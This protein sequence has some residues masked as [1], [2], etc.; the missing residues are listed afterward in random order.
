MSDLQNQLR[1][2]GLS[3]T[4]ASIYICGVSHGELGV[5]E[6]QKL[7]SIKRPTIYHALYGLLEKGL[8]AKSGSEARM[9][10]TFT[11]PEHLAHLAET[12]ILDIKKKSATAQELLAQV[13]HVASPGETVVSH[14]EGIEGVKTVVD[15]ALYCRSRQWDIIAPKQNFFAEFSTS[16]N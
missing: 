5:A 9:R 8:V 13:A 16:S 10:F 15:E 1:G 6:L 3:N 14:Y 2:L 4:E 12:Q 7:T 11:G